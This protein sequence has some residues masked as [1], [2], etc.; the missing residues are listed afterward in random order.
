[1]DAVVAFR[2]ELIVFIYHVQILLWCLFTFF[3]CFR[4]LEDCTSRKTTIKTFKFI[5]ASFP[6]TLF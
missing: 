3:D 4:D 5:C 2:C 1:M 6:H